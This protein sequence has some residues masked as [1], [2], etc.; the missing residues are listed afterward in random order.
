LNGRLTASREFATFR[1]IAFDTNRDFVMMGS[2]DGRVYVWDL[3]TRQRVAV[4]PAQQEYVD[5]LAVTKD[6]WVMYAGFGH[7]V[8]LWNPATGERRSWSAARPTSNLVLS[9]GGASVLFGTAEGTVETWNVTNGQQLR[10]L[11]TSA[12]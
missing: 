2:Q 3:K 10:S 1:P 11:K 12:P 9:R 7:T 8:N 5:I 6:G 4:S